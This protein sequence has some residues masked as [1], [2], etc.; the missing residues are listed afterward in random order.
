MKLQNNT[1]KYLYYIIL[2]LFSSALFLFA[3]WMLLRMAVDTDWSK[4]WF[5]SC[6]LLGN[7]GDFLSG[8]VGVLLSFVSTL[9]VVITLWDQRKQ[10]KLAQVEQRQN[11]FEMTYYNLLSMLDKTRE[12]A[13]SVLKIQSK[14]KGLDTIIDCYTQF[15]FFYKAKAD[16]ILRDDITDA[17]INNKREELA[18]LYEKFVDEY[19][20]KISYYYRYIFH[21]LMFV[22][23]EYGSDLDSFKIVSKYLNI[24]Q[25][26]LSDEEMTLIF[27]SSFSKYAQDKEGRL[28]FFNTLDKYQFFENLN[29]EML[30]DASHY[31]LYPHTRYKFLNRDELMNVKTYHA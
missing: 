18:L 24:L 1:N 15:R 16:I 6:D 3:I 10:F 25:A 7:L 17:E 23:D 14:I 8:T 30:F 22:I 12:S 2:S 9:L 31:K 26:Q 21:T 5:S 19:G 27:Y 11:R 20:C 4:T 28:S 13:N 29:K